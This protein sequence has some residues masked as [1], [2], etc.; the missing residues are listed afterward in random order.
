MQKEFISNSNTAA[1]QNYKRILPFFKELISKK[2]NSISDYWAD[3]VKGFEYIFEASPSIINNLR[4]HCYHITGEFPYPYRDHHNFNAPKLKSKLDLLNSLTEINLATPEPR[5]L[6]GF[7]YQFEDGLYNKDT[8]KYL[9][10]II[11]LN[12]TGI[13]S[14]INKLDK[15][16]V[17]EIGAGWGGFTHCL[18]NKIDNAKFIIADL[19]QTL[20]FSYLYLCDLYPNKKV[21]LY[22]YESTDIDDCDFLLIPSNEFINFNSKIDLTVNL[23]SFQEM[24]S[25]Q[26]EQYVEKVSGLKSKYIYSL[27]RNLNKNNPSLSESVSSIL[28][29]YYEIEMI[30]ILNIPYTNINASNN[31]KSLR[32]SLKNLLKK[33]VDNNFSYHHFYGKNP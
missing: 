6:G 10:C 2:E 15:P 30:E 19:P 24:T 14:E 16:V 22:N 33:T 25:G 7:G 29:R 31:R 21:K 8:L 4:H 11:A 13:L 23:C 20:I 32:K 9:E 17:C 26:V 5:N 12:K 28:S 18:V 27:N 3:E 1:F